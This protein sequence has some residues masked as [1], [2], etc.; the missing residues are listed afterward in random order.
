[1]VDGGEIISSI[2]FHNDIR[3]FL[4]QR[5][6]IGRR[7]ALI[8]VPRSLRAFTRRRISAFGTVDEEAPSRGRSHEKHLFGRNYVYGIPGAALWVPPR[9]S[10][11]RVANRS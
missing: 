1:M 11:G 5:E 8:L 9:R 7:D 6:A 3:Y 4:R 2:F 10:A